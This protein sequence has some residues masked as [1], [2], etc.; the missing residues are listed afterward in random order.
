[1]K[2]DT[3]TTAMF[4]TIRSFVHSLKT[5]ELTKKALSLYDDERYLLGVD[6]RSLAYGQ[7]DMLTFLTTLNSNTMLILCT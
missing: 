1:M 3:I 2:N 5:I 4:H 7:L 6:G